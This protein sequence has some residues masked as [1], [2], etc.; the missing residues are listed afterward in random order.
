[1]KKSSAARQNLRVRI[2]EMAFRS[3][4]AGRGEEGL[5]LGV[6]LR[7]QIGSDH[8]IIRSSGLAK[9]PRDTLNTTPWT[10]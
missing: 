6:V 3:G 2:E 10:H 7:S 9:Y 8:R 5:D 4:A 1:M